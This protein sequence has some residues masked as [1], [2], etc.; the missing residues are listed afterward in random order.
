MDRRLHVISHQL[1]PGLAVEALEQPVA[2]LL[3]VLERDVQF[4]NRILIELTHLHIRQ[5]GLNRQTS[6]VDIECL[7]RDLTHSVRLHRLVQ[8]EYDRR[9]TVEVDIEKL[10][11][12]EHR[13]EQTD[14]NQTTR[15][16][17]GDV[18]IAQKVDVGR[19]K[20]RTLRRV[21]PI[22]HPQLRKTPTLGDLKQIVSKKHRRKHADR[23]S[24]DQ[25]DRKSL[26][27]LGPHIIKDQGA[28]ERC[29]VRVENGRPSSIESVA[30]RHAI[31]RILFLLLSNPLKHQN[32][33][34]DTH[35]H[36]QNQPR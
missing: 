3:L 27:L 31:R 25:R 20:N 15:N 9:A 2:N 35:P 13:C 18:A 32:I 14:C 30:N 22:G 8:R 28:D 1:R 17:I 7:L 6:L 10:P 36:R 29:Q 34:V 33:G 5:R 16:Q 23:Q 21:D 4:E 19:S 26:D 24:D 11:S 12:P